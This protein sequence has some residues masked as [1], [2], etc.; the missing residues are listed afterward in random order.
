MDDHRLV[1]DEGTTSLVVAPDTLGLR[2]SGRTAEHPP[3]L[4]SKAQI[5][6][7]APQRGRWKDAAALTAQPA[8]FPWDKYPYA[9]AIVHFARAVGAARTGELEIARG[10][11]ARLEA[12]QAALQKQ[13]GFDW[14]TD[15]SRDPAAGRRRLAGTG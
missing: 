7:R 11:V 3:E 5:N 15:P 6:F 4:C 12:I 10:A 2:I 14:A 8:A 13:K 9:E 1:P